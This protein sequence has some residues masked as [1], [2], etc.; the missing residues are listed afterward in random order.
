M[1]EKLVHYKSL[2]IQNSSIEKLKK[3]GYKLHLCVINLE[4]KN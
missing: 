3:K 4:Q 2:R 1:R